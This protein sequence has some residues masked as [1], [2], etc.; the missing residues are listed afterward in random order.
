M[1][2]THA[3]HHPLCL[4]LCTHALPDPTGHSGEAVS[5][6]RVPQLS[7]SGRRVPYVFA[8]ALAL[9]TVL[10]SC[11]DA[12]QSPDTPSATPAEFTVPVTAA[13]VE[14]LDA[15]SEP[16]QSLR[17]NL[18]TGTTQATTLVTSTDVRQQIDQQPVQDISSPEVTIPL[19]AVVATAATPQ[20]PTTVVDLTLS[21]MT[22]PDETLQAALGGAEG[23][24][25]GLTFTESGAVTALRLRPSAGS[26][27]AARAAIEQAF[28]QA[29]YRA[30]ALPTEPVGV[31]AR[32][33]VKQDVSSEIQ[34][35]QT[36]TVTVTARDG[37]R[38]T[39]AVEL[40]QTPQSN[41]WNL[42]GGAG[43]LDIDQYVMAGSG[44][45]IVDLNLPLPVSGELSVGGD[46]AYSDPDGTSVIRQS[47]T[48]NIRWTS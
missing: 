28:G 12:E 46:Q 37:D 40:S 19:N 14:V 8:A 47:I 22:T 5:L 42:A 3:H 21:G 10:T 6:E 29:V 30:V 33:T 26:A 2:C 43:T 7:I 39:L 4:L 38:L 24:G 35:D 48:N 16:R 44:T 18:P 45:M 27:N 15:G 34:L 32:W 9:V 25:A 17:M 23:S 13:T 1:V 11:G 41:I 36:T 20:N 31:G